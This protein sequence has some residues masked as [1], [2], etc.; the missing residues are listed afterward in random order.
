MPLQKQL[1][2][3]QIGA[4]IDTKTDD[5]KVLSTKLLTLENGIFTQPGKISKRDG[6]QS[7]PTAIVGGGSITSPLGLKTLGDEL[8]V[9][10]TAT[11]AINNGQRLLALSGTLDAWIDKGKYSPMKVTNQN[12]MADAPSLVCSGASVGNYICSAWMTTFDLQSHRT[13][14]FNVYDRESGTFLTPEI[15]VNPQV[16]GSARGHDGSTNIWVCALTTNVFGI[17]YVNDPGSGARPLCMR[18]VTISGT[19]VTLG[20][21]VTIVTS[22]GTTS[23]NVGNYYVISSA[24]GGAALMATDSSLNVNLININSA[25]TITH[26]MVLGTTD[27]LQAHLFLNFDGTNYWAYWYSASHFK[28]SVVSASFTTVLAQTVITTSLAALNIDSIVSVS[29]NTTS[30]KIFYSSLD[31][32]F[33]RYVIGVGTLTSAGVYTDIVDTFG[34]RVQLPNVGLIGAPVAMNGTTYLFLGNLS[35]TSGNGFSPTNPI[36]PIQP[37]GFV[38]DSADYSVVAKFLS[39]KAGNYSNVLATMN[40]S[41]TKMGIVY[42]YFLSASDLIGGSPDGVLEFSRSVMLVEFDF[43]HPDLYQAIEDANELTWNG[44]QVTQYDQGSATELGFHLFPEIESLTPQTSTNAGNIA[45]G[46]YE[47]FAVYRWTDAQGNLH[48]SAPS[49]GMQVVISGASGTGAG[50]S[51]TVTSLG[52]SLKQSTYAASIFRGPIQIALFRTESNG[53]VPHLTNGPNLSGSF[54][55]VNNHFS[56]Q[57]YQNIEDG[58]S[59]ATIAV[60]EILYT[61]GG[62]LENSAPPPSM[63]MVNY[64]NRVWIMDSEN[65]TIVWYCK[66]ISPGIAVSF[67]DQLVVD[68]DSRLGDVTTLAAFDDKIIF[69]KKS[70]P[71]FCTG[72]GANDLGQ[73]STLSNPIIVSSDV[74]CA[75]PKSIIQDMPLGIMFKSDKGIYLMDRSLQVQYIGHEV[76]AFNGQTVTSAKLIDSKSQIRFLCSDGVALVYD[77]IYSQWSTFTNHQGLASDVYQGNYTYARIDQTI[78]NET[79]GVF[80]DGTLAISMKIGTAWIKLTDIQ[81]YERIRRLFVVGDYKS[82]HFLNGQVFFDYEVDE[83]TAAAF[84]FIPQNILNIGTTDGVYQFRYHL[85]RQ[86]CESVRFVLADDFTGLTPGEGYSLSQLSIEAGLKQGGVKLSSYKSVG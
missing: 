49:P 44:G 33:S 43:A 72:D 16:A 29:I 48:Q 2:P 40:L 63:L 73:G 32:D 83:T 80:L 24:G 54:D 12:I 46:T 57:P 27:F 67:S 71:F 41:A 3:I 56:S 45:D 8:V 1:L 13:A 53:T 51:A 84:Q 38:V 25:G 60:Q 65:P 61:E 76:E 7:L 19:S 66:S 79:P 21:Q 62:V 5:K 39:G 14:Y 6:Y 35:V 17:F 9:A 37:T 26:S 18:T 52:M 85:E 36:T 50:V 42:P 23:Q 64:S 47:Y 30:Q 81:N 82:P 74:G 10:A 11:G 28:F 86:K 59:D 55:W 34:T 22:M 77:Y 70:V 78:Y 15:Q 58:N 68:V 20:S 31:G 69:F 75:N 4:G